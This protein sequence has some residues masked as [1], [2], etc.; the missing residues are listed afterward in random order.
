[1]VDR[2]GDF[3]LYKPPVSIETVVLWWSPAIFLVI[4]FIAFVSI[5][6][7]RKKLNVD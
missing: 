4:A 5:V 3:V 7:K 2:Y 1:M 6:F